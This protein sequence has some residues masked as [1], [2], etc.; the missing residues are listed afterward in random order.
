MP[1]V[2]SETP[3]PSSSSS[4]ASTIKA[5][6]V[7]LALFVAA[8]FYQLF[9]IPKSFP[10]SHY[11]V[12]GIKRYS[13]IAD[14]KEAYEKIS[15]K[16]NSGNEVPSTDDFIKIQYAYEFLTNPSWK[17]NYDIFGI[18]EHIHVIDRVKGKYA[19]ESFSKIKLPLL[20]ATVSVPE[21][22]SL[23]VITHKDFESILKDT[24]PS[25]IQVFSF[26]SKRCAQF[27]AVW[28][29][30]VFLL[31]GVANT[32]SVELGD[33]QLAA[34]FAEKKPT[35]QPFFRNGLPSLVAFPPDCK[36]ADCVIRFDGELSVDAVTDWFS[37]TI[38]GLPRILYYSRD[39]LVPK[40]LSKSSPHK[41][42][43]IFF[44]KTGE[45]AAPFVRQ[46]AQSY[47]AYASF[48]F[49]LWQEEDS[50]F[51]WNGLGVE[52]APAIVFLKDPGLKPVVYHGSVN[53]SR[54]STIMEQNKQ[55]ELP[56][57]RSVTSME[58][59][60]D[61]HGFSRAGVD[62]T[63]WYCAVLAGRL[64]PEFDKMRETMRR[65]QELL[66]NDGDLKEADKVESFSPAAAAL[67]SRRLTFAWLDG[68]A[69]KKYCYF[70]LHSGNSSESIYD[71]CG[72]RRDMADVPRIFIVRYKRNF[73]EENLKVETK[74]KGIW[75][76]MKG[77]DVAPASQLVARYNGSDETLQIIEWISK[78]IKDGDSRDLPSF[79]TK[80]PELVPEDADPIWVRGAQKVL[81]KITIKQRIHG[82]ITGIYDRL[83]DPRNGPYLLL[84]ALMSFGAIWLRRSRPTPPS[85]SNQP[86]Q[87]T[88]DESRPKRR[89]R[90]RAASNKDKSP[91]VTDVDP[92]DAFQ[93]PFSD[94]DS[95]SE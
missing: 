3:A 85:Q 66:S 55:Q 82:I 14:A 76:T 91:S 28:K 51:W 26:G 22:V 8:M 44:S 17:S 18:D 72:P 54:F 9:V 47:W 74:P 37:T 92:K 62:T 32:G 90:A 41:V 68:E 31:D 35:G 33:L 10:V 43:V 19:G 30:I 52:S 48:A 50:S 71:T 2:G 4:M 20:E 63:T 29:R 25:L 40:F 67:N 93:M 23:N 34:Y 75:D 81:S 83:G 94:S 73:T 53:S 78:I 70:C 45:R 59:G 84:G 49:V 60:C 65:V 42:R 36:T 57:L 11:D 21:D 46:A 12:L 16:W 56:Q 88:N 80:T 58:L 86:S 7:P 79:R 89:G 5:Y 61:A 24:R 6:S 95:G 39:T 1:R 69:Q 87:P 27:L 77:D 13:S 15:S 38:L 64:G